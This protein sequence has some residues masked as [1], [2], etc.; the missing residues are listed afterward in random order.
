VR[1]AQLLGLGVPLSVV[2]RIGRALADDADASDSDGDLASSNV[3][4]QVRRHVTTISTPFGT[5][6]Q[7]W[8]L[9]KEGGGHVMWEVFHPMAL[10]WALCS[11][12]PDFGAFLFQYCAG[13]QNKLC[14]WTDEQSTG[15]KLRPDSRRRF[16]GVYFTFAELPQWF[17]ACDC[18]WLPIGFLSYD[19][20]KLVPG[21][22]SC[23]L[24]F[25]IRSVFTGAHNLESGIDL[26]AREH[27]SFRFL[28]K[29]SCIIADEKAHKEVNSVKGMGV[30]NAL[31]K[32]SF[33]P[34]GVTEWI[35]RALGAVRVAPPPP[36]RRRRVPMLH[37]VQEC[38]QGCS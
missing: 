28:A 4:A 10:L 25:V 16:V 21:D 30:R 36:P 35:E 5:V 1:L 32:S 13:V 37:A 2:N 26:P 38:C 17:R 18:G 20:M 6:L 14:L 22:I 19:T 15:N 34:V 27:G 7:A 33:E 9:P 24:R 23:M 31:K 29:L 8:R 12:A 3:T 11:R